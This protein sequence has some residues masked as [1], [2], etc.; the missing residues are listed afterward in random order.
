MER[1]YCQQWQ[2]R[3]WGA[4]IWSLPDARL[5]KVRGCSADCTWLCR[6][7]TRAD[8]SLS[9]VISQESLQ[10]ACIYRAGFD[11]IAFKPLAEATD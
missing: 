2:R 11:A 9:H 6:C 8:S 3:A 10:R 5:R 4:A 1:T 7:I